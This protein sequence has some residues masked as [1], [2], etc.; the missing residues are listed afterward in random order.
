MD[1]HNV[2]LHGDLHEEIYMDLPPGLRRQGENTSKH[3]YDL[4][5]WNKGKTFIALIIYVDDI[6]IT[7]NDETC[8]KSLKEHLNRQFRIKDLG[9][10][11]YFLGIEIARSSARISLS[12][13]KYV[14]EIIYDSGLSGC[15]PSII[16]VEQNTKLTTQEYDSGISSSENDPPLEDPTKY[17]RLVGRLIYLTMTHPDISY[18]VHILSQ[19]MHRPKHSHMDVAIKVLKYLKGCP[20]LGHLLPRD[21]ELVVTAHCDSNWATCPMTR[22]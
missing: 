5:T 9:E 16:P 10:P 2:F 8:I 7:G 1:V 14:L 3:D 12:Q 18:A 21:K 20:G 13:R 11:K 15:K 17:Q 22:K 4:F 6:L 19:F